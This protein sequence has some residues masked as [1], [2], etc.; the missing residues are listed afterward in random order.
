MEKVNEIC[1]SHHK[2]DKF[3]LQ[4]NDEISQ[5]K[6]ALYRESEDNVWGKENGNRVLLTSVR[7]PSTEA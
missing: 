5:A 2:N 7:M 4:E 3:L 1:L 6:Y